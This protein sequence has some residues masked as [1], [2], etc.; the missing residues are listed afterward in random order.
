LEEHTPCQA[1]LSATTYEVKKL[2]DPDKLR[3]QAFPT[4]PS[5]GRF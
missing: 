3:V 4:M 2:L 1:R 5:R